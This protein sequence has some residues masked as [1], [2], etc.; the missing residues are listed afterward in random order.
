M[1]IDQ[2]DFDKG[3]DLAKQ[4]S[5]SFIDEE[6]EKEQRIN[7][8]NLSVD[9]KRRNSKEKNDKFGILSFNAQD[10]KNMS[11]SP[12]PNLLGENY[13]KALNEVM[14]E[15]EIIDLLDEA[16]EGIND[17][18]NIYSDRQEDFLKKSLPFLK[19]VGKLPEKYNNFNIDS[20]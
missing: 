11:G 3:L 8:D 15:E 12:T 5:H 14:S 2:F 6:V 18:D 17:I 16:F 20:L 7:E 10:H 1:K 19:E 9:K 13:G 4:N